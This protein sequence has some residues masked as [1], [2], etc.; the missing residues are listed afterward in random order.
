MLGLGPCLPRSVQHYSAS[1]RG[2]EH[3]WIWWQYNRPSDSNN[4]PC[5]NS[6]SCTRFCGCSEHCDRPCCHSNPHGEPRGCS[7]YG[8]RVC[9]MHCDEK[10][11]KNS[12][13][14]RCSMPRGTILWLLHSLQRALWL[15]QLLW[16]ALQLFWLFWQTLQSPLLLTGHDTHNQSWGHSN[17][18]ESYAAKRTAVV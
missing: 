15:L 13:W 4:R 2:R 10:K 5:R 16:Q 11:E 1:S 9:F 3:F 7:C 8:S 6:N 18:P 17:P 14:G 12:S